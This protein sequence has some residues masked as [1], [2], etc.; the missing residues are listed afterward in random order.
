MI[1]IQ[2]CI[3][4]NGKEIDGKEFTITTAKELLEMLIETGE[5]HINFF[6]KY[7]NGE[8][9]PDTKH[10]DIWLTTKLPK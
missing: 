4:K 10:Q 2:G 1:Y 9:T 8:L 3:S 5:V 6:D 7:K